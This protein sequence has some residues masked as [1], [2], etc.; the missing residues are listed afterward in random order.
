MAIKRLLELDDYKL[1]DNDQDCRGWYCMDASGV[2]IG[3]VHE[4]LVNEERERVTAVVLDTGAQIPVGEIT[5]LDG[6]VVFVDSHPSGASSKTP[7]SV[8]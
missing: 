5:L 8:G 7:R 1:S 6:L 4:M 2:Q 3:T